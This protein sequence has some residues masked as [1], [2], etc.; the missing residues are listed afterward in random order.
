MAT[1]SIKVNGIEAIQAKIAEPK[2]KAGINAAL[3]AYGLT[4]VKT[5][6]EKV[7]KDEGNLARSINFEKKDFE[8]TINVNADYAAYVEFGTR[9]FAAAYVGGLEPEWQQIAAQFKGK[10]RGDYYDFLNRILDWVKRKNL[11]Q[12]TNSYTGRKSTKKS[13]LIMVA[14]AVALSILR[15]GIKPQP[16]IY[17]AVMDNLKQLYIDL[18]NATE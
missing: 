2:F 16:F 11:A 8:I 10:G 14:E 4:V 1:F 13:D 7:P 15:N 5:A 3:N 17:P 6:K 9:K 12:I 18:N